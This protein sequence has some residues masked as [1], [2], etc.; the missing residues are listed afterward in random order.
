MLVFILTLFFINPA[1]AGL[2]SSIGAGYSQLEVPTKIP[3]ALG[4]AFPSGGR[5]IITN[6]TVYREIDRSLKGFTAEATI[7]APL[8]RFG[9]ELTANYSYLR[10]MVNRYK[11]NGV[12]LV[13]QQSGNLNYSSL[14]L[15][16]GLRI[17]FFKRLSFKPM[18]GKIL[19]QSLEV[20]FLKSEIDE[21]N[22][23]S[24]PIAYG[25]AAGFAGFEIKKT[26]IDSQ[27]SYLRYASSFGGNYQVFT[28]LLTVNIP[29]A[30]QYGS[31]GSSGRRGR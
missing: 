10:G 3:T 24:K 1:K 20:E 21:L 31:S 17:P 12:G 5:D 15:F 6:T 11:S 30:I 28:F 16:L 29:A 9:L 22:E 26:R 23:K 8:R 19:S 2:Y 18:L 25:I 27:F 7:G 4:G 14:G 13:T